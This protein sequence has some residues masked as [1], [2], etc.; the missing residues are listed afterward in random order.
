MSAGK[1]GH[2]VFVT[3]TDTG[4]GKT[5]ISAALAY[6]FASKGLNVGIM[7]PVE[8]GVTDISDLGPD[9]ALLR[10]AAQST[11]PADKISPYRFSLPASPHQAAQSAKTKIDHFTMAPATPP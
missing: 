4:V 5:V 6:H 7:K 10:W 8:T 11:D 3:G 2:A 9:A 1:S